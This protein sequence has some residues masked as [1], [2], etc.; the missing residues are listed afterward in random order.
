M[1]LSHSLMSIIEGRLLLSIF[2]FLRTA[3]ETVTDSIFFPRSTVNA[4]E[5]GA[6]G[7]LTIVC[8]KQFRNI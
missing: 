2:I 5:I 7:F 1:F 6:K 4:G 3:L 8:Q